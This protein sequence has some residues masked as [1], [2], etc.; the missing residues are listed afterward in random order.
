MPL[1]GFAL[2]HRAFAALEPVWEILAFRRRFLLSYLLWPL[3]Y[4]AAWLWRR[5]WLRSTRV[6][7]V[8]GSFGKTSA[9]AAAAAAVGATFDVDGANYGSFLAA[10]LLRHRP[11]RRPLVIEAGISR[12][13][14]M[15]GYAR[16][17]RPDVVVLTAVGTEHMQR[18]GN[19]EAIAA[20]K[21]RLV[22]ELGPAGLLIVNGDDERCRAIGARAAGRVVR[23]GF[24]AD[25]D[26]R[27]EEAAGDWPR[28]TRLRLAGPDGR[29]E[30]AS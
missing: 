12:R 11:R 9:A 18:L 30:I 13:G 1:A 8:T 29:L 26:W 3:A 27:I 6:I 24:T 10:A 20:E 19:L 25:C 22:Q 17:L 15:R 21:A 14:Q 5:T 23:V 2:S 4:P 28:G 16:L 7:A